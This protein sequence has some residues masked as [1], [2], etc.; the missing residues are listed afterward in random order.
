MIT[1]SRITKKEAS[2][3]RNKPCRTMLSPTRRMVLLA[4]GLLGAFLFLSIITTNR[5][6]DPVCYDITSWS[7]FTQE[8][9]CH[10]YENPCQDDEFCLGV[11]VAVTD[12]SLEC[13][14]AFESCQGTKDLKRTLKTIK[15]LS[16]FS[17]A[18]SCAAFLIVLTKIVTK[19]KE[20]DVARC[21]KIHHYCNWLLLGCELFDL[22]FECA[23]LGVVA[24]I[25]SKD[26]VE[27]LDDAKCF[28]SDEDQEAISEVESLLDAYIGIA[29][30][31]L[32]VDC[33][34]IAIHVFELNRHSAENDKEGDQAELFIGG[35][36]IV[37]DISEF[38]LALAN[39]VLIVQ[40][41]SGFEALHESM[42]SSPH[43]TSSSACIFDCCVAALITG[44]PTPQTTPT[45]K[46]TSAPSQSPTTPSPSKSN[47][48][49]RPT[50][51][52]TSPPTQLPTERPTLNPSERTTVPGPTLNPTLPPTTRPPTTQP[53]S[54]TPPTSLAQDQL[55][56]LLSSVSLDD[57]EA[58]QTP[59]TPQN[60]AVSWL[61]GNANLSTYSDAKKIQRY[62]LATLYYS[63]NG[64]SWTRNTGWLSD[65]D[66]CDWD[67][68][69][70]GSLCVS[71]SV[72]ELDMAAKN[73]VGTV[74]AE[75]ALLSNSLS[76][77]QFFAYVADSV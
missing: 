49:P 53:P 28:T 57:G 68:T 32:V 10:N 12:T 1:A 30:T 8:R 21:R 15:I 40:I 77:C 72:A 33:I 58:L 24:S 65:S 34:L 60:N 61:A 64:D 76:E 2:Q 23:V 39:I 73:L 35:L 55:V 44:T 19:L 38:A 18:F 74:P 71:G 17:M 5:A 3:A 70:V 45:N 37:L 42:N 46:T 29:V 26:F 4:H 13:C 36:S 50:T 63:T 69:V 27:N 75:L 9:C 6:Q 31:E 59:S 20:N 14:D 66:E 67:Y 43:T 25:G 48:T 41:I 7:N 11:A 51:S 52:P 56:A 47:E 54:T 16:S 22:A 62:V